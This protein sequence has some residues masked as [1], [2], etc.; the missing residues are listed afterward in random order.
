[1]SEKPSYEELEKKLEQQPRI[2]G[3]RYMRYRIYEINTNE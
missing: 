2:A 3:N 1:M